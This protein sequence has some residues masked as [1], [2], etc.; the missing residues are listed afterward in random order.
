[1][2]TITLV[3]GMTY[4]L[5][6]DQGGGNGLQ[7]I[8]AVGG[9]L[10]FIGNGASITRAVGSPNFRIFNIAVGANLVLN[11]LSL[12]NGASN[13]APGGAIYAAG[14]LTANNCTLSGNQP[15]GSNGQARG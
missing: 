8:S 11:N 9:T 12:T 5:S 10:T 4:S 13:A 15:T 6:V 1:G 2:N 3:P 7:T 14:N